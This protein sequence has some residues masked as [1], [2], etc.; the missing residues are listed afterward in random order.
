[1]GRSNWQYAVGVISGGHFVSHLYILT[2]PPLF[3]LMRSDFGWGPAELGL[4]ISV[5]SIGGLLQPVVGSAVDRTG[6]KKPLVG[7]LVLSGTGLGFIGLAN[8]ILIVIAFAFFSGV[9]QSVFHPADYA[10][11]DATTTESTEGKGFSVH[12]LAGYL[13]FAAAPV[14][15]RILG[16]M[17]G[18][19]IALFVIGSLGPAYALVTWLAIEP[20]YLEQLDETE[21]NTDDA[22]LNNRLQ[23][24]F[25]PATVI[26][27]G[28]FL[29][30]T[31]ANKSIQS[32]TGLLFLDAFGFV[33]SAGNTA[34]TVFFSAI[35][36]SIPVGGILA[37]RR[38]PR[39]IFASLLA[40]IG[41]TLALGVTLNNWVS[42]SV[43]IGLF[44]LI[45]CSYGLALPSRDR[46]VN[47]VAPTGSTGRTFGFIFAGISLGG[48]VGPA[49]VGAF[50]EVTSITA[51]FYVI[52]AAFLIATGLVQ[53]LGTRVVPSLREQAKPND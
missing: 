22:D 5:L 30:V 9:G 46:I 44:G 51:G 50:I 21:V 8:S 24:F 2:L 26:L 11:I 16:T 38:S 13:G 17:Y 10:I 23:G 35:S 18:W 42:T 49:S 34:L 36:I 1:M 52:A 3:P 12:T 47:S 19:R 29:V 15:A 41:V 25:R 28:I 40:A 45:G 27:L 48:V 6:A 37:D 39:L 7:G 43:A 14:V 33:E 20:V 4:V 32:F 53:A 31:I